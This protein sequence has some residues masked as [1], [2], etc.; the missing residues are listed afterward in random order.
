[1]KKFLPLTLVFF[2]A[3]ILLFFFRKTLVANG[4]D[5]SFLQGANLLIFTVTIL[6]FLIL[7]GTGKS[8]SIRSVTTGIYASFIL[9]FFVTIAALFIYLSVSKE[10]NQK[11]VF[12]A[13]GL[14]ILYSA[15][16]VYQLLKTKRKQR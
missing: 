10:I 8:K 2:I 5:A 6:G 12:T 16:E 3:F 9:K 13:M 4:F 14:Y 1:M 11:A 7:N 15:V